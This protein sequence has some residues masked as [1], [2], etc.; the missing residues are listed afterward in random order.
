M[1]RVHS[2]CI[3][4]S[5]IAGSRGKRETGKKFHPGSEKTRKTNNRGSGVG[6]TFPVDVDTLTACYGATVIA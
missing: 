4:R 6:Q 3:G 5:F 1:Q 2:E